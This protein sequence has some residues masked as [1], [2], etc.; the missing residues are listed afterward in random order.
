MSFILKK[1]SRTY[2]YNVGVQT[3]KEFDQLLI[4]WLPV[5]LELP[6]RTFDQ[7]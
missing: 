1:A 3:L 6:N 2:L 4:A 7:I 5:G